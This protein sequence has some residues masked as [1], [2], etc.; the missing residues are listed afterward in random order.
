MTNHKILNIIKLAAVVGRGETR[1][2][3]GVARIFSG[4]APFFP[5]KVDDLF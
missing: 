1:Q 2:D 5:E 4:G 3:I